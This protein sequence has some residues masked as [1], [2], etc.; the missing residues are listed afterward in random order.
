VVVGLLDQLG[1]CA[2]WLWVHLDQ[3]GLLA[4]IVGFLA[5]R[6]PNNFWGG[7]WIY[8]LWVH[9]SSCVIGEWEG[10]HWPREGAIGAG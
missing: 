5:S 10:A 8:D 3:L 2:L 6:G 4:S 7:L 1:R 9:V